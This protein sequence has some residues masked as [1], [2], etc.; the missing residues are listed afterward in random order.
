[1]AAIIDLF[2][3]CLIVQ[4]EKSLNTM[5]FSCCVLTKSKKTNTTLHFVHF[6]SET[7]GCL[8]SYTSAHLT[9]TGITK[10][11][12]SRLTNP[13]AIAVQGRSSYPPLF[14][15]SYWVSLIPV[16]K[17][18]LQEHDCPRQWKVLK[19]ILIKNF[20]KYSLQCSVAL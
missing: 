20:I 9:V 18:H 15:V 13:N 8:E 1:M 6:H 3:I 17:Y 2:S 10:W 14:T 19:Q 4:H 7:L 16:I 12:I 5:L 11:E